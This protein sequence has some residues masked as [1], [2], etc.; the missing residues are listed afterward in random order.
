MCIA[1]GIYSNKLCSEIL[2]PKFQSLFHW[3]FYVRSVNNSTK[4]K[5]NMPEIK[6]VSC[7]GKQRF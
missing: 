4:S 6:I 7:F 3:R 5:D 1:Q 2:Q